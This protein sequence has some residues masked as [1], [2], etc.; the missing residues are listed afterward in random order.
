MAS[1]LV[2]V[3]AGDRLVVIESGRV[4]PGGDDELYFELGFATYHRGGAR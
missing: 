1:F 4:M 2:A 3:E